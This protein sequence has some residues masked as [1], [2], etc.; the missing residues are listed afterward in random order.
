SLRTIRLSA[1]APARSETGALPAFQGSTDDSVGS[2]RK[3]V[4][5]GSGIASIP[6][7]PAPAGTRRAGIG[8]QGAQDPLGPALLVLASALDSARRRPLIGLSPTPRK[9]RG[10]WEKR[11]RLLAGA[12]RRCRRSAARSSPAPR[13]GSGSRRLGV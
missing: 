8:P 4:P 13:K 5:I 6:R 9:R 2:Q 11:I 7:N 3:A 12:G 10:A 1:F